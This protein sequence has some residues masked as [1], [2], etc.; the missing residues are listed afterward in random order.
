MK[1]VSFNKP[2]N[3]YKLSL[4]NIHKIKN[5]YDYSE[6][7]HDSDTTKYDL[8]SKDK[9]YLAYFKKGLALY[10]NSKITC[11]LS[12]KIIIVMNLMNTKK[13]IKKNLLI[14][15]VKKNSHLHYTTKLQ[16]QMEDHYKKV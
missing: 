1:V 15:H 12:K 2:C 11:L 7:L 5:L 6:I 14:Y 10:K 8:I 13:S 16:L 4:V 9:E 3:I